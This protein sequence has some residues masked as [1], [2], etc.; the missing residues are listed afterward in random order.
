MSPGA[1]STRVRPQIRGAHGWMLALL[2]TGMAC[3]SASSQRVEI[4]PAFGQE[5]PRCIAVPPFENLSLTSLAGVG[6]AELLAAQLERSGHVSVLGPTAWAWAVAE[7]GLD[8]SDPERPEMLRALR[9]ELGVQAVLVGTVA[10]YWYTDDPQLYRDKQPSVAFRVRMIETA[11]GRELWSARMSRTP[12]SMRSGITPVGRLADDMAADL[13]RKLWEKPGSTREACRFEARLT[14]GAVPGRPPRPTRARHAPAPEL[15]APA[16]ALAERLR[17]GEAFILRD[18]G[19]EYRGIGLRPGGDVELQPL[20]ELLRGYPDLT[21][22]L[23]VHTDNV[24]EPE[25]LLELTL[26]QAE[27]LRAAL[28]GL[29][30]AS[31]QIVLEARGGDEPL[32]PNINRRNRQINRR[33]ELRLLTP[34][35]GGW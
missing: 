21:I 25:E 10:E 29:G 12:S 33:V 13:V 23:I 17:A 14:D 18:V 2:L 20:A 34:P 3:G 1:G 26:R 4:Q 5:S 27:S 6:V 22:E 32:L 11:G 30:A 7:T 24:G 15:S 9:R 31:T 19:F 35:S 28:V 8:A 16:A